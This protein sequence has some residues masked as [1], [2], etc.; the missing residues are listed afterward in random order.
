MA[1]ISHKKVNF[2]KCWNYIILCTARL[3]EITV[4]SAENLKYLKDISRR[5]ADFRQRFFIRSGAI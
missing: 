2:N 5:I 3:I 4:T 1:C